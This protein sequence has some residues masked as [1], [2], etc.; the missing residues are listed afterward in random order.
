[1]AS[2]NTTVI[3]IGGGVAGLTLSNML[4]QAG[5]DFVLLEK[6]SQIAA[7]AGAGILVLP[8]GARILDQLGCYDRLNSSV[9]PDDGCGPMNVFGPAGEE[10]SVGVEFEQMLMTRSVGEHANFG[11]C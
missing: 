6:H 3:I 1:M 11:A 4:E 10:I 8:P 9:A 5:I 2:T 7:D